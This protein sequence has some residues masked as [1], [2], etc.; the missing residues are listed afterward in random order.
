MKYLLIV[1]IMTL[2]VIGF[3]QE[4]NLGG[5]LGIS[6]D[7]KKLTLGGSVEYRPYRSLISFNADP[8]L[9][10]DENEAILTFPLYF[11]K[12]IGSSV[13]FC[14][15]LGAFVRSNGNYGWTTG[16]SIEL[17]LTEKLI[18]QAKGDYMHDYYETTRYDHF[19]GS[20]QII[21]SDAS[22]WLSIGLKK[23]IF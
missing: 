15:N 21:S 8:F 10:F 17:N 12:I 22:V 11:K 4:F 16:L 3:P 14:P 13:R 2:P 1:F 18:L 23:N 5:N 6:T 9:L 20:S 7:T 19:G